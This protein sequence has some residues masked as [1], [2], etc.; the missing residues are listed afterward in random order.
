MKTKGIIYILSFL[1]LLTACAPSRTVDEKEV[2]EIRFTS[3][4][5]D[6]GQLEEWMRRTYIA[7]ADDAKRAEKELGRKSASYTNGTQFD[8]YIAKLQTLES[9]EYTVCAAEEMMGFP[10]WEEWYFPSVVYSFADGTSIGVRLYTADPDFA[11]VRG[12]AYGMRLSVTQTGE[13]YFFRSSAAFS[14]DE[15]NRIASGE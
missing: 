11:N 15:I 13:S 7:S 1:L 2:V 4:A 9:E 14:A 3:G 10:I 6:A 5:A 8:R 12:E